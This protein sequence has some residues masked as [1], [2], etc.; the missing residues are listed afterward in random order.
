MV[1]AKKPYINKLEQ[2]VKLFSKWPLNIELLLKKNTLT[3]KPR[4]RERLKKQIVI[5]KISIIKGN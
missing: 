3:G 5:E 2:K 1:I 4:P